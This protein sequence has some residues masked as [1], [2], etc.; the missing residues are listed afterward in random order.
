MNFSLLVFQVVLFNIQF[1][2][3]ASSFK[4]PDLCP[5][6]ESGSRWVGWLGTKGTEI[7]FG[8]QGSSPG[9]LLQSSSLEP[10]Q[11]WLNVT[12]TTG[13]SWD[14]T[15][16]A[17]VRGVRNEAT[18]GCQ[19]LSQPRQSPSLTPWR[20]GAG[21]QSF[22]YSM[23]STT[24]SFK[25]VTKVKNV[26][27]LHYGIFQPHTKVERMLLTNVNFPVAATTYQHFCKACF[28]YPTPPP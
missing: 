4:S 3:S 25:N 19:G 17:G 1:I 12:V 16:L 6:P 27:A 8:S 26:K 10:Y 9:S 5:T 15:R 22:M 18:G 11:T 13:S 2:P 23:L 14:Q 7:Y 24:Y 21:L 28:R 20:E